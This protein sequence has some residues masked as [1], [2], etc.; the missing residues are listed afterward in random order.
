MN[1]PREKFPGALVLLL[2]GIWSA[3]LVF[4]CTP[5][6][7]QSESRPSG[8]EESGT[9]CHVVRVVDGDTLVVR[10][11]GRE[12]RVRLLGVDTPEMNHGNPP[13]EYFAKRATEFTRRLAERSDVVL[14]AEP[15][16]EDRDRYGRLLRYVYLEDGAL[17]NGEIIRQGY[18]FAYTRFPF[19][20]MEEFRRFER[21]ARETGR[22]LWAD[23]EGSPPVIGWQDASDHI[24]DL[25][26]VEGTVV[27]TKN[28]GKACFLNF[29]PDWKH[30]FTAVILAGDFPAFPDAPEDRYRGRVVRVRGRIK[31]YRGK[32]EILV[33]NP[34]QITTVE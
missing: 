7:T 2:A 32:P 17:L 30:H 24:G 12:E 23:D 20:R 3:L 27:A 15:G 1:T 18:G 9:A 33:R 4:A 26:I 29:H 6:E 28:T 11:E 21:E 8:L 14:L 34:S 10:V 16:H 5:T 13:A 19:A 31:E 22:G 25:A